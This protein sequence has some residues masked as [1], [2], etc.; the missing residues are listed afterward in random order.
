MVKDLQ[1][2]SQKIVLPN[3][4]KHN[5]T[6]N[7]K[8]NFR[9]ILDLVDMTGTGAEPSVKLDPDLSFFQNPDPKKKQPDPHHCTWILLK[10]SL[11]SVCR[12]FTLNHSTYIKW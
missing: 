1:E 12:F 4:N 6:C 2:E 10:A 3:S 7:M 5:N 9:D 8:F 11:V